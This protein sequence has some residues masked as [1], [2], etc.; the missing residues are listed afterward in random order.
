MGLARTTLLWISE[1]RALRSALPNYRFIRRAVSRF[2]PGEELEDALQAALDLQRGGIRSILTRL[3]ENV[4]DGGTASEVTDHY[5]EVTRQLRERGVDSYL[6]VKL[7]QLG[8]DLDEALCR[9][10]LERICTAAERV[11]TWV[12]IDM[13]Q[14]TYVDRTLEVYRHIRKRHTNVGICLQAYL[15]RTARDLEELLPLSPSIRLVKGAYKEPASIAFTRR[16]EVDRNYLALS[17][18]LLETTRQGAIFGVATH[19][20]VLVDRIIEEANRRGVEKTRYEFQM[21]YG[22]RMDAQ[23]ALVGE[24][25]RVRCLIS[26]GSY[27]FPWYVRRLAERPANVWFVL[28]NLFS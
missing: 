12:W 22:I 15:R 6:S 9:E 10:N 5:V 7:T 3:G 11:G 28:K 2:M 26:Y 4:L 14:S 23:R 21:L 16:A 19:D 8:L 1:N 18:S 13:E 25:H 27:W 24:G 20:Q 17:R